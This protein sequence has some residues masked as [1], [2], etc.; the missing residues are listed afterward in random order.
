VMV[1]VG[2]VVA[3]WKVMPVATSCEAGAEVIR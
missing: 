3:R 1:R 2:D